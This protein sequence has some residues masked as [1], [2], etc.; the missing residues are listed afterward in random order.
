MGVYM[1]YPR[2]GAV[3]ETEYRVNTHP[4]GKAFL[5]ID[6]DCLEA[7]LAYIESHDIFGVMI[8][9]IHGYGPDDVDFLKRIPGIRG[10]HIQDKIADITA[11]DAV[12]GLEYLL[13]DEPTGTVDV[14]QFPQLRELRLGAWNSKVVNLDQCARLET[15]YVRRFSPKAGGLSRLAPKS[16]LRHLEIVQSNLTSLEGLE[17]FEDLASLT[18]RHCPKLEDISALGRMEGSLRKLILDRC[19][20]IGDVSAIGQLQG[21]VNLSINACGDI[22]SIDFVSALETLETMGLGGGTSVLDGDL[23]PLLTLPVLRYAGVDKK[24]HY[25]HTPAELTKH[26]ESRP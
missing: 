17:Q 3:A 7:Q 2:E 10:V 1:S 11:L 13:V 12:C 5:C 19:K 14:S 18:L 9:R 4:D 22:E 24:K 20:G 23:S 26:L 21:L 8:G 25:S 15:L 16:G 6:S